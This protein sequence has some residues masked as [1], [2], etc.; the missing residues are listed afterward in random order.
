M[1]KRRKL[2]V[3]DFQEAV[4]LGECRPLVHILGKF[5]PTDSLTKHRSR[6]TATALILRKLLA[7]GYYDVV[8]G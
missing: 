3:A 1:S 7:E 2:D 8:Q 5:N 4:A 6:A